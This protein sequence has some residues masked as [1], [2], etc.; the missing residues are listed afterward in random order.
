MEMNKEFEERS[1]TEGML[2]E[3]AQ[4][5]AGDPNAKLM[6][7]IIVH[8]GV[9]NAALNADAVKRARSVFSV[10]LP[11]VKITNQKKSG[12]CWAFAGLNLLKR[13]AAAKL[14]ADLEKFELSQN[15]TTFYDKLEKA[16]NFYE[17]VIAFG[18]RELLD[19][20]LLFLLDSAV[21]QGGTWQ[22]LRELVKKYGVVPREVMPETKDSEEAGTLTDLLATKVRKDAVTLRGMLHAGKPAGEIREAKRGMLRGVYGML[23]RMLGQPP[24]SFT[25]EYLDKDKKY[26]RLEKQTPQ[27]FYK[28]IAESSLDD[29][30]LVGNFPSH[31]R[32][33]G[34][35]YRLK[36]Y[37]ANIYGVS[38]QVVLDL[39]LEDV[40]KMTVRTLEDGEPVWFGC[41]VTRMSNRDLEIFDEGLYNY[42]Q[43]LGVDLH[44]SKAE[45]LDFRDIH[46]EHA[47]VFTG[48]N[49]SD[50]KP[51]RWK[52]EN[53][54]GDEKHNKG[55]FVMGDGFFDNYVLECAID[56]KYLSEAQLELLKQEPVE[57]Y[58]WDAMY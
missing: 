20:E 23:C 6:E 50:G 41:N 39:P 30:V 44:M 12:R 4:G 36:P 22:Y 32:K 27:V 49:I 16:N 52:V 7:S 1:L 10:E 53:S 57:V 18:D 29:L 21:E 13:K 40:K 45:M 47:M 25:Y 33:P 34:G 55:I 37:M 48:V 42:E 58:P 14:G 2:R 9:K 43:L 54:W 51:D 31:G 56:R 8:N 38:E 35:L 15:Y 28:S 19:R 11:A 46:C 5:Y 17:A 3:F 26:H 24:L